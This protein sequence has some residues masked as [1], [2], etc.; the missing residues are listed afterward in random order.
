VGKSTYP[1]SFEGNNIITVASIDEDGSISDF[2]NFS[3]KIVDIAAIGSEVLSQ[4]PYGPPVKL[5]GTSMAAPQVTRTCGKVNHLRPEWSSQEIVS[6]ILNSSKES[7]KLK[8]YVF[9]GR[10][11][12][13]VNTVKGLLY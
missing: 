7:Q 12:D 5:S 4:W 2:S 11:L 1:A 10:L 6:Y 8:E 9:E 13:E 3:N